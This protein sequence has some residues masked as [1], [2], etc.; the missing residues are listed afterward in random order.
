MRSKPADKRSPGRIPALEYLLQPAI[1]VAVMALWFSNPEEPLIYPIVLA[2]VHVLL[3]VIEH[4]M[5][6]R[7]DWLQPAREKL[8]NV[9]LVVVLTIGIGI[10]A[11]WYDMLLREPLAELRAIL[12]LDIWP[13]DWPLF[14][15]VLL[16]FFTGE[17]IWY[18]LHRMEHRWALVWRISGHGVHHSFKKLGGL[19]FGLNHPLEF[20]FLVAPSAFVELLFGVGIAA[21]GAS[22]LA[23]VQASIAHA[24]IRMNSR[25]IGWL[26]TT[27]EY[28]IHHHS[29]V[30]EESNTN[31]GCAAIVWD[32]LFGTFEPGPTR[33]AGTGPTEPT[34]WRKALMPFREPDDTAIAP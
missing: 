18:W 10:V 20:F 24:N 29:V 27:N 9:V 16:V 14:A 30:M 13:H 33:E 8:M 32:R 25:V 17:F 31:Y 28:H 7:P 19:N 15:Q 11:G 22:I 26:F 4:W 21:A 12:H 1:L 2:T 5:P 6:A 23:V 34:L 3:G